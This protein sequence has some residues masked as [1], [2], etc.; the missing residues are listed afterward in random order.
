MFSKYQNKIKSKIKFDSMLD[1][2]I[3]C[4]LSKYSNSNVDFTF[5]FINVN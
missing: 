3:Y 2:N 1:L 5:Y 4:L